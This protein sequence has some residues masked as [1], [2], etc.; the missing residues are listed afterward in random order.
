MH[1]LFSWRKQHKRFCF[2]KFQFKRICSA[3]V[4]WG[5]PTHY[6]HTSASSSWPWSAFHERCWSISQSNW[7]KVINFVLVVPM[8]CLHFMLTCIYPAVIHHDACSEEFD[9]SARV[10]LIRGPEVHGIHQL[11]RRTNMKANIDKGMHICS[12]RSRNAYIFWTWDILPIVG[13][14]RYPARGEIAGRRNT[15]GPPVLEIQQNWTK[16]SMQVK[17]PK[18]WTLTKKVTGSSEKLLVLPVISNH[19]MVRRDAALCGSCYWSSNR[20]RMAC[21]DTMQN[22]KWHSEQK[23]HRAPPWPQDGIY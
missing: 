4:S 6:R 12:I 1:G 16:K 2:E 10:Q 20:C 7:A 22:W 5:L 13:F 15:D 8:R 9:V 19:L 18:F 11:D 17:S 14:I 23:F 21:N 3:V